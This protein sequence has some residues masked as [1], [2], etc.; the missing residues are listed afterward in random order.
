MSELN[1]KPCP[2]CGG[3]AHIERMG[4]RNVSMQIE[5]WECGALMETGEIWIDEHSMW[6]TRAPQSEWISVKDRLPSEDGFVIARSIGGDSLDSKYSTGTSVLYFSHLMEEGHEFQSQHRASHVT[7]THWMPLP[8]P[9][10]GGL[11]GLFN[12]P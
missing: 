12:M 10:K 5:C 1:L 9:P 4:T 8:T 6:N 11:C 7:V 3:A 2:F